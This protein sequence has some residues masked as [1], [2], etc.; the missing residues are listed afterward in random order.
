MKKVFISLIFINAF[1]AVS[2]AQSIGINNDGSL[3][4][5]SAMLDVKNP[6]KGALL[7]RVALTGTGDISTIVS[8]AVSLLI[9]NTAS[10]S[11]LTAVTPGY[12]YWS[13]TVW[14]KFST[15]A[16]GPIG[17]TGPMGPIGP[18][19]SA[20]EIGPAGPTGLTG[21]TGPT[22]PIGFTGET[23]PTGPMGPEGPVGPEGPETPW[24]P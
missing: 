23:G 7:P 6:N 4:S 11:G 20:G 2:F 19:G 13:G 24:M 10:T 1:F 15:G 16:A 17:P 21:E 5:P 8:P 9:Y 18:A 3:P 22:G 14:L 12:Y